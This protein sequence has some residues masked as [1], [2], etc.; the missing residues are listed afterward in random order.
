LI[1]GFTIQDE[2]LSA[3]RTT[4]G[5]SNV[6][7]VRTLANCDQ[8]L[9]Q[10]E[11]TGE[12]RW[13]PYQS[14]KRI[15]DPKIQ[16]IRGEMQHKDAGERWALRV[17]AHAL[18][19]WNETTGALD[20]LDVDPL[21]HQIQLVHK[22]LA[23]GQ[24]NWIIADDVGLGKT[25]EV[26]LLIAALDQQ[27]RARRVL[28]ICP[29]GLTRQ[30]QDEMRLKFDR[31]YEVYGTDFRIDDVWKWKL[32]DHVIASLDLTKPRGADDDGID[33]TTHFGK[34]LASGH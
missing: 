11:N 18:R 2:P 33:G 28:I 27:N 24:T 34:L 5:P 1:P 13:L 14:L 9:V 20:R 22:I 4:L 10:L 25:I 12:L 21:P 8:A 32:H 16:F 29:P 17:M 31:T 26:G 19:S 15:K 7:A 23:S 6:I 3:T 30:W